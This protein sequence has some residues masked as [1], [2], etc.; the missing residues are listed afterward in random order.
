VATSL[1]FAFKGYRRGQAPTFLF[2]VDGIPVEQTIRPA[3]SGTGFQYDFKVG[4]TPHHVFFM[5]NPENLRLSSTVGQWF[6]GLLVVPPD[7]ASAFS[8][9]IVRQ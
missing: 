6:D 2:E 9:T 8:V 5:V 7:K 4:P 3:P 1:P